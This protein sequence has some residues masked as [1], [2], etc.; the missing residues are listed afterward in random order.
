M[1]KRAKHYPFFEAKDFVDGYG[2]A[3]NYI[4]DLIAHLRDK[5]P[6]GVCPCC[7]GAGCGECRNS[8]LV[9]RDLYKTLKA[10][11]KAKETAR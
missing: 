3:T 2:F 5:R 10:K 6:A 1:N 9:P 8:G 7:E 11:A 4:D